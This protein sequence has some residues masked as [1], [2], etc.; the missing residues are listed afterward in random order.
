MSPERASA[1]PFL[2]SDKVGEGEECDEQQSQLL[3]LSQRHVGD[4]PL[5][6]GEQLLR[7]QS[8]PRRERGG[9]DGLFKRAQLL[10]VE[11]LGR[12]PSP[13]LRRR[14]DLVR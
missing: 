4:H 1:L 9:A 14:C 3:L 8:S 6:H 11:E 2:R 12:T 5:D 7:R 10:E 13:S